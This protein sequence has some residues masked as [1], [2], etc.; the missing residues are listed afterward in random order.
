MSTWQCHKCL[1]WCSAQRRKCT[2]RECRTP[3][4]R[5]GDGSPQSQQ[6]LLWRCAACDFS[7]NY[8][9]RHTCFR[10]GV[11]GAGAQQHLPGQVPRGINAPPQTPAQPAQRR[12]QG[13]PS[14]TFAQLVK[15]EAERTAAA[16][17][18]RPGVAAPYPT[19]MDTSSG[20]APVGVDLDGGARVQV[21]TDQDRAEALKREIAKASGIIATLEALDMD[22]ELKALVAARRE[23]L[24][25]LRADLKGMKPAGIQLKIT[26]EAR[27]KC[28]KR[29]AELVA[30][31]SGLEACLDAK[32]TLAAELSENADKL[33]AEI[34]EIAER[35]RIE[36]EQAP[37]QGA[38][39]AAANGEALPAG[40]PA[41]PQPLGQPRSP[42]Q[43]A[44]G[45]AATLP[46]DIAGSF[47]L[48]MSSVGVQGSILDTPTAATQHPPAAET[49]HGD[50]AAPRG[51]PA[52]AAA[53]ASDL[54]EMGF[55]PAPFTRRTARSDPYHS[56]DEARLAATPGR[57]KSVA[58][59]AEEDCA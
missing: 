39:A 15:R 35:Q 57:P 9:G 4:P 22:D 13:L 46:E 7:R 14:L 53:A 10:C 34:L 52:S 49:P 17:P 56:A 37:R 21:Q 55:R 11:P 59:S 5:G 48:W 54:G 23:R 51:A 30:E 42:I 2:T 8:A 24:A 40:S 47:Q 45:L 3:K 31:I 16:Y 12:G 27:D 41:T 29:H 19:P 28:F 1:V 33:Q 25:R 18:K 36:S 32:R 50:R 43:W 26:M 20:P 6:P 44:A 38:M 58:E